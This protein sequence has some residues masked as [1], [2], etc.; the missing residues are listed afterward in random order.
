MLCFLVNLTFS[1]LALTRTAFRGRVVH[2]SIRLAWVPPLA[3][4]CAVKLVAVVSRSHVCIGALVCL[5]SVSVLA[6][7]VSAHRRKTFFFPG[8]LAPGQ[9]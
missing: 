2:R 6:Q 8:G 4:F 5:L 1:S 3:K 9:R 7:L